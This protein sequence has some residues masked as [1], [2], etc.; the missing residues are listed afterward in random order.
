MKKFLALL[1]C[2]V[3]I[4][5]AVSCSGKTLEA[6]PE[7]T[8]VIT[9]T[10]VPVQTEPPAAA[11]SNLEAAT[12][13]SCW[14]EPSKTLLIQLT[15]GRCFKTSEQ[16]I[17]PE[18]S[19]I[20]IDKENNVLIWE[21]MEL[22]YTE[23]TVIDSGRIPDHLQSFHQGDVFEVCNGP[24]LASGPHNTCW[25]ILEFDNNLFNFRNQFRPY[26]LIYKEGLD[27]YLRV[28]D[29]RSDVRVRKVIK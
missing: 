10:S 20:F 15:D 26:V 12:V 9:P 8:P 3:F 16:E 24:A 1:F 17:L 23:I 28:P 6:I 5:A 27:Y 21:N 4:F 25:E 13:D 29:V 7:P 19:E 11:P 22:P 2:C 18:S 14:N